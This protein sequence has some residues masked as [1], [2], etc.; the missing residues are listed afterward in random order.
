MKNNLFWASLFL[1]C[2]VSVS[3]CNQTSNIPFTEEPAEE[4]PDVPVVDTIPPESF[5][6]IEQTKYLLDKWDS[7]ENYAAGIEELSYPY[8]NVF[9]YEHKDA[10]ILQLSL[11]ETFDE[12]RLFNIE[13]L[14]HARIRN[15]YNDT[16]YYYRLWNDLKLEGDP[17]EE[18]S[19][20]TDNVLPR[21]CYVEP[22]DLSSHYIT[23]VR[24]LGG[25]PSSLGGKVKQGLMYRGG[26]LTGGKTITYTYDESGALIGTKE[27][28][29]APC[30]SAA[31]LNTLVNTLGI[32]HEIDLRFGERTQTYNDAGQLVSEH[33]ENGGR[34]EGDELVPGITGHPISINSYETDFIRGADG[35]NNGEEYIRKFFTYLGNENNYPMYIHCYIG[36][37]R[38][39]A[40][41]YLALAV[42]GVSSESLVR[43]YLF[44]NFGNIGGSRNPYAIKNIYEPALNAFNKGS[45]AANAEAYLLSIGVSQGQINAFRAK[46]IEQ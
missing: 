26:R 43:D 39:G 40:L 45:L 4:E 15:L 12:Y 16:T 6:S 19:L 30:Y 21:N 46:M 10:K 44:S 23:N 27:G 11:S 14:D 28:K 22:A 24:D 7:I 2:G 8:G 36:T 1:L 41:C 37:D 38:T 13:G 18:G 9:N 34:S 20:H 29:I 35:K 3:S 5:H 32:K 42:L 31:G 17:V 33:I 25:Y